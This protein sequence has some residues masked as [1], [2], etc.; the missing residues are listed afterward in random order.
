MNIFRMIHVKVFFS[1]MVDNDAISWFTVGLHD[2]S[3]PIPRFFSIYYCENHTFLP[4][5]CYN[6]TLSSFPLPAFLFL[7]VMCT[8][9][10]SYS[11]SIRTYSMLASSFFNDKNR[12][13]RIL[14]FGNIHTFL[15]FFK[16]C[17]QILY[18]TIVNC[19]YQLWPVVLHES[20]GKLTAK[21]YI[22]S[23][24]SDKVIFVVF[25]NTSNYHRFP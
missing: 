11:S 7:V 15:S 22:F 21:F 1:T 23:D 12:Q 16:P 2:P 13:F 6:L 18:H 20:C 17:F 5:K 14:N 24:G 9:I 25:C 10:H 3:S 8:K 19:A 4:H